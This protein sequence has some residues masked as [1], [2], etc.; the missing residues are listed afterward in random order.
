MSA[1]QQ[2][3]QAF[4]AGAAAPT[5]GD[6]TDV[7]WFFETRRLVDAGQ[8]G[9]LSVAD[10]NRFRDARSK[11]NAPA[12]ARLYARWLVDGDGALSR[13]AADRS[14]TAARPGRLVIEQMPGQIREFAALAGV[15]RG[16][17]GRSTM[18][19]LSAPVSAL[20]RPRIV[21]ESGKR[22]ASRTLR[23]S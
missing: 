20:C 19:P 9:G 2:A 23:S 11:F 18:A 21:A 13:S 1:C 6:L 12:V 8:F 15:V 5:S 4:T 16:R 17:H 14:S 22:A 10:L 7:Q 3:F